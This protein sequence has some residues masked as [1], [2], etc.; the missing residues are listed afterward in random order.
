MPRQVGGALPVVDNLDNLIWGRA[1]SFARIKAGQPD[2]IEFARAE[3]LPGLD[4]FE[5]LSWK[6]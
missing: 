3:P 4:H 5:S 2:H 6:I 1:G